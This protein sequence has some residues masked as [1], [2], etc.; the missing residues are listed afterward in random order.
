MREVFIIFKFVISM[1]Y[2]NEDNIKNM[3]KVDKETEV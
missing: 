3:I 2:K 1:V